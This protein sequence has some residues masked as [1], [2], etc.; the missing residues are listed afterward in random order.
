MPNVSSKRQVNK[1][2]EQQKF[3][4]MESGEYFSVLDLGDAWLA[5]TNLQGN[6]LW[7]TIVLH[8]L[9]GFR[10][11]NNA[12]PHGLLT[13][14]QMQ[15]MQILANEMVYEAHESVCQAAGACG[16]SPNVR[17]V[18]H[19]TDLARLSGGVYD[20]LVRGRL[21]EV[22]RLLYS[23]LLADNIGQIAE[24]TSKKQTNKLLGLLTAATGK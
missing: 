11:Y 19:Q 9:T 22:P 1:L 4:K 2:L 10:P 15:L 16:I 12:D 21:D 5:E 7:V 18:L 23:R 24:L 8:K 20:Q 6:L 14:Q 3:S 13:P 17:K